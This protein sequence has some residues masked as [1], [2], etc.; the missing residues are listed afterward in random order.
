[1]HDTDY[2][3]LKEQF[4]SGT[5]GTSHVEVFMLAHC[6]PLLLCAGAEPCLGLA[7][8]PAPHRSPCRPQAHPLHPVHLA[9]LLHP[10]TIA[11]PQR[12]HARVQSCHWVFIIS[13]RQLFT[14]GPG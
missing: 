9:P 13:T 8:L 11:R 2:K 10:V 6:M 4:V 14:A 5:H 12:L 7:T 3:L 1:M